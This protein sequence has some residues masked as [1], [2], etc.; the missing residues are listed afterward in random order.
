MTIEITLTEILGILA[1]SFTVA[2]G[3]ASL[4]WL[5][6]RRVETY[7]KEVTSALSAVKENLDETDRDL[8]RHLSEFKLQV[9]QQYAT[10]SQIKDLEGKWLQETERLHSAVTNLTSRIDR[11]ITRMEKDQ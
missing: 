2:S 11:V 9:A 6:W 7:H 5:V 10:W 4:L 1:L 8:Y 3:F